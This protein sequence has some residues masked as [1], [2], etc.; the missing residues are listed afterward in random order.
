[1]ADEDDSQAPSDEPLKLGGI[2]DNTA[3]LKLTFPA[4]YTVKAPIGVDVK[5]DYAE[6]HSKYSFENGVFTSKREAKLLA[7]EI[8]ASREEDYAAFR[9][10][11]TAD[12]AQEVT[13][14]NSQPGAAGAGGSES[15]S[16]LNE[17]AMQALTNQHYDLGVQLLQRVL[18]LDPKYK[19]AWDNL[20][21]AYIALGK[22]DLAVEAFKKQIEINPYDEFAYNGLGFVYQR[23][24]K[25]DDA[26]A[27]FQK[28][29]EINPLDQN[30]H[31]NLGNLLVNQKKFAEAIPELEKAIS[32]SP[33][34][35]LLEIVLGQAYIAT[36]Q[37]DKG[38][39]A[40]EK[41]ISLSPSPLTWNNIAYSLTEQDVQLDRAGKYADSAINA[42]ETQ[43]RDVTLDNLRMQDLGTTQLL[44]AV[45]DTKGWVDFK[46][47]NMDQAVQYITAAWEAGATGDE[48]EHLGE[49]YEKQGKKDQAIRYYAMSL[50]AE[51]ASPV[52]RAKLTA[53]GL[54]DKD[55]DARM[56]AARGEMQKDRTVT[57]KKTDKGTAEFYLLLSP[58]KVEQ[59]KYIKGDDN[60]KP[61]TDLLMKTDVGMKFPPGTQA[62]VVRRAI[63]RCGTTAPAPC[64]VELL[65]SSMVR[66][67]D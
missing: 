67:L 38:M 60:L 5:R 50:V 33:K 59:V 14:Q 39:A 17:S 37:T 19:G 64:T 66:S 12:E 41:A 27:M 13:L 62:H 54:K 65:P 40:F 10:V 53:M 23:Q 49:I 47:G 21:R 8:P 30:A 56:A 2:L 58:G 24:S 1:M 15:A 45:W 4:K 34:N 18:K 22:D 52:A 25:F 9:R 3:D 57:L 48:A 43:L 63:V 42:T 36:N 35:P 16:D 55:I 6:Y 46:Q 44:F 7:R 31:A 20:G 29:I 32:I 51:N 61:L 11:V 28:Q 26:I